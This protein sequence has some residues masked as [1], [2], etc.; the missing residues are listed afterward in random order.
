MSDEQKT[1]EI[2]WPALRQ[3]R[4]NTDNS[5]DLFNPKDGF[6]CAFDYDET[7][8]VVTALQ[9]RAEALDAIDE[10]RSEEGDCVTILC[11]NP[12]F[13]GPNNAVVCC[14][15][16]TDWEDRRFSGDT[17]LEALQAA[18]AAKDTPNER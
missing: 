6:V 12:D 14:G 13:H 10:L 11:D 4:H 1:P 3:Y 18:V 5:P 17:L 8:K 7:L 2:L 15:G 16:W 9:S